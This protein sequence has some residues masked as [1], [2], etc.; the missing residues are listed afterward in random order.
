MKKHSKPTCK[1]NIRI[2]YN[3]APPPGTVCTYTLLF[4]VTALP[5]DRAVK[6]DDK[7]RVVLEIFTTSG[8]NLFFSCCNPYLLGLVEL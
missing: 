6:K 4:N 5:A 3:L 1:H 2:Q 8:E 7:K